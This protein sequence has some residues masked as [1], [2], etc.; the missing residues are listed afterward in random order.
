MVT[1]G[2][3]GGTDVF[4]RTVR[5]A[6]TTHNLLPVSV[7]ITNRGAGSGAEGLV[8]ARTAEE[9]AHKVVFATN[10]TWLL[11][12][13]ARVG[14]KPEDFTPSP[15]WRSTRSCCGGSMTARTAASWV[16]F[17]LWFTVPLLKGPVEHWLELA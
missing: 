15:S 1:P 12:M 10:N 6:I 4:V 9:D 3:G 11:P 8:H 14:F 16:L 17:E 5:G 13:V 7:L 2:A